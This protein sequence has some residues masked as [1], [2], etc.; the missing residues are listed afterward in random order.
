MSQ[1]SDAKVVEGSP[2][3][4]EGTD[5]MSRARSPRGTSRLARARSSIDGRGIPPRSNAS[6]TVRWVEETDPVRRN[7]AAG[8]YVAAEGHLVVPERSRTLQNDES[9]EPP[10]S[11][12]HE[13]VEDHHEDHEEEDDD[14]AAPRTVPPR[15]ARTSARTTSCTANPT[16]VPCCWSAASR[17]SPAGASWVTRRRRRRSWRRRR[18]ERRR[19]R[20]GA[21]AARGVAPN[22]R[23][24]VDGDTG[25]GGS[26]CLRRGS[27]RTGWA[28][29]GS[30]C[31]R[32]RRGA[33]WRR[34]S[35]GKVE[36]WGVGVGGV[37]VGVDL[38]RRRRRRRPS[39]PGAPDDLL[40]MTGR[41]LTGMR[42]T[43]RRDLQTK[44]LTH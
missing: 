24:R 29:V 22:R 14:A 7:A 27:I 30:A 35:P 10:G 11:T 36:V 31:T 18:G 28:G 5:L 26:L 16:D 13:D 34:S 33:R 21:A 9:D 43:G 15:A 25:D 40:T 37:H 44:S 4:A 39:S 19:R 20:G 1:P 42:E 8:G 38:L 3:S 41:T 23:R 17:A 12:D 2:A 6:M 32:A